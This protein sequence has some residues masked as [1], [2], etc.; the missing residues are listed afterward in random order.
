MH[1]VNSDW[2]TTAGKRVLEVL[3]FIKELNAETL[4][5]YGCGKGV[6]KEALIKN[7]YKGDVV[8]YDPGIPEHDARKESDLVTCIDVMEHIEPEYV[9]NVFK[10]IASLAKKGVYFLISTGKAKTLLPDGRNAH[11]TIKP[12]NFWLSKIK[13]FFDVDSHYTNGSGSIIV[14]ARTKR[15]G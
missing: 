6:L 2:G 13:A 7:E 10:D 8:N 3:D 12:A 9:D 11:L 4:L 5:D 14:K 1:S 15:D